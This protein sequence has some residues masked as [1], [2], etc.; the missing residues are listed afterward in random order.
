[1]V[2]VMGDKQDVASGVNCVIELW[3]LDEFIEG[4]LGG[5][6]WFG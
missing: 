1:M 5:G 6:V 2:V 4:D 3:G